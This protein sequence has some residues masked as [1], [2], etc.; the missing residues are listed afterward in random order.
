GFQRWPEFDGTVWQEVVD[1]ARKQQLA[2]PP[3]GII[4]TDCDPD[5]I[6][7]A[8]EN[9]SRAVVERFIRF[10]V[11]QFGAMKPPTEQPGVLVTNPPYGAR[12]GEEVEL[13]EL[14]EEMSEVLKARYA[15]WK[16][17]IMAGNL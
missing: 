15:G 8:Q 7:A 11:R 12:L 14:Y 1:E 6:E 2:A 17:F 10:D 9:A 4:A 5:A 3:G 13:Q 16:V